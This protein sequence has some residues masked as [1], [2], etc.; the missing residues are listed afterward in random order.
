MARVLFVRIEPNLPG[1]VGPVAQARVRVRAVR[2]LDY[3][4]GSAPV[5][6]GEYRDSIHMVELPSGGFRIQADAPHAIFVEFGTSKMAAYHTLAV[7]LD[8]AKGS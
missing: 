6:T 4:K 8:A 7:A 5:D 1:I 3:A 2:V